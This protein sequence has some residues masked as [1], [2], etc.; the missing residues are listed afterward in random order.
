MSKNSSAIY[1]AAPDSLA[2]KELGN[3]ILKILS[4][5]A[6]QETLRCALEV[7][8]KG[9]KGPEHVSISGCNISMTEGK[10]K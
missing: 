2:I 1:I 8:S 7:F 10:T 5:R 6:D 4:T 3:T 9:V